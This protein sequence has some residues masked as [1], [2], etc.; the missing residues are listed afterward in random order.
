MYHCAGGTGVSSF[1]ALTPLVEWV[2]KGVVPQ[3][4]VGSRLVDGKVV[5]TPPLCPYPQV[6][7]YPGAGSV[8]EAASFSCAPARE[9]ASTP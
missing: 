6:A 8:D 4:I 1:D 7:R 3:S 2:E 9:R 5:R